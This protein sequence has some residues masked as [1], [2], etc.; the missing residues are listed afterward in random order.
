MSTE[1]IVATIAVAI[2]VIVLFGLLAVRGRNR[3]TER[4]REQ[5]VEHRRAA[6]VHA[7]RAEQ[8]E[9]E[10][11]EH[12]ARAEREQA[13]AREAGGPVGRRSAR[14]QRSARARQADRPRRHRRRQRPT[15]PAPHLGTD[16]DYAERMVPI[17][18]NVPAGVNDLPRAAATPVAAVSSHGLSRAGAA[19]EGRRRRLLPCAIGHRLAGR[20]CRE[21][22]SCCQTTGLP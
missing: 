20:R 19:L 9:A 21:W 10:I 3:K 2:I 4:R 5:A 16:Q 8:R 14:C 15:E 13:I 12:Q 11:A 18:V 7:A 22:R 17:E 6:E 1:A